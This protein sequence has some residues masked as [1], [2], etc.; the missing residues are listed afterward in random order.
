[1]ALNRDGINL[2][3]RKDKSSASKSGRNIVKSAKEKLAPPQV[4]VAR[5]VARA[6]GGGLK[7]AG[8]RY[9]EAGRSIAAG[10][11]VRFSYPK[12]TRSRSR[13]Y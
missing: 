4:Q 9:K 13:S 12:M 7:K 2:S 3:S 8:E 11:A 5:K 6:I 10:G 1:M